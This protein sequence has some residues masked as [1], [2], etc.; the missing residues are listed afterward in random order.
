M[1]NLHFDPPVSSR[2]PA[3]V[4]RPFHWLQQHRVATLMIASALL[5]SGCALAPLLQA[6]GAVLSGIALVLGLAACGGGGG[7]G[8]SGGGGTAKSSPTWPSVVSLSLLNSSLGVVINGVNNGGSDQAG[9]SLSVG[10]SILGD[11]GHQDLLIG[12]PY[13]TGSSGRVY[14]VFGGS[15]LA[16]FGSSG[17]ASVSSLGFSA[18]STYGFSAY[19]GGTTQ[20]MGKVVKLADLNGDGAGDL[21]VGQSSYTT[22]GNV[23]VLFGSTIASSIYSNNWGSCLP[24]QFGSSQGF[25][26]FNGSTYAGPPF[27]GY[28][29]S[30]LEVADINGDGKADL[31]VGSP[32]CLSAC[33]PHYGNNTFVLPGGSQINVSGACTVNEVFTNTFPGVFALSQGNTA[34]ANAYLGGVIAAGDFNGDTHSDVILGAPKY[35]SNQGAAFIVFG[36]QTTTQAV[37]GTV[38]MEV[39]GW[40]DG[41]GT[42]WMAGS[43][44][45]N[46]GDV[47]GDKI[48]DFLI[49]T[50]GRGSSNYAL[51]FVVFGNSA[52]NAASGPLMLSQLA[53]SQGFGIVMTLSSA[54]FAPSVAAA[55][56]VD[57]NGDG[58]HDIVIGAS[59]I[60]TY[61]SSTLHR[62][63]GAV[64]VIFGGSNIASGS[65][66]FDTSTLNGKN[67][68]VVTGSQAYTQLGLA[69][70]AGDLNGDGIPDVVIGAPDSEPTGSSEGANYGQVFV[71]FGLSSTG[72]FP[73]PTSPISL[74]I[75]LSL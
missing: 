41:I 37:P 57:V 35:S 47:N 38:A 71:I 56:G 24:P 22:K 23:M 11:S 72:S 5:M 63:A 55:V 31:L 62:K 50:P 45:A 54:S 64:F 2:I 18:S 42:N 49:S 29:G 65:T 20:G 26:V 67:G 74:E 27:S 3:A 66:T 43:V 73:A 69:L 13:T 4:R 60:G 16:T 30:A 19:A 48:D 15:A 39:S 61:Q 9:Y 75:P 25:A 8:G 7:G 32:G 36:P 6:P 46:L 1:P 33:T 34:T 51:A 14:L 40:H 68:F 12:A 21:I 44:V 52:W 59:N 17:S 58:I 10:P 28:L 70:A 53:A